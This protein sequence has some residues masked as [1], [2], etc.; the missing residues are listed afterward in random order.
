MIGAE[1]ENSNPNHE[2]VG[3]LIAA[4]YPE[5]IGKM[6][7]QGRFRLANGRMA[8]L[9]D[10]DSLINEKWLAISNLDGGT[11]KDGKIYI[12]APLNFKDISYLAS[13]KKQLNGTIKKVS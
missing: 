7:T 8:K 6:E 13:E 11:S 3:K 1:I 9:E 12:A 4:A 2:E 5:R 10:G